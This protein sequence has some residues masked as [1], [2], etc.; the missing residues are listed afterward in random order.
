IAVV[1]EPA[2]VA[3]AGEAVGSREWRVGTEVFEP[4]AGL[5]VGHVDLAQPAGRELAT[6]GIEDLDL[7]A[8]APAGAAAVRAPLVAA[9]QREA[10]ALRL[11]G[12]HEKRL[13]TDQVA[14]GFR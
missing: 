1:A 4:A 2:E 9:Q 7:G 10:H 5:F 11:A 13:L 3:D 6:V 12:A 14:P 8:V